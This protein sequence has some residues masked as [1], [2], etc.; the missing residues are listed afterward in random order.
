MSAKKAISVIGQNISL[1]R[2]QFNAKITE[3]RTDKYNENKSWWVLQH[4]SRH[5]TLVQT[6]GGRVTG[7]ARKCGL[8]HINSVC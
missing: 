2:K 6:V 7:V 1:A 4:K 3:I 8:R 5:Y